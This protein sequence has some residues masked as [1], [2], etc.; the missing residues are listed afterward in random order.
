[1]IKPKA[2]RAFAVVLLAGVLIGAAADRVLTSTELRSLSP[3]E[4]N[5]QYQR[6]LLSILQPMNHYPTGMRR[7]MGDVWT[8]TRAVA[9]DYETLCQ[10]DMLLLYYEPDQRDGA[11][12]EWTVKPA[13]I[14]A[15]R[16]YRFVAPPKPAH[17]EAIERDG[18]FRSAFDPKCRKADKPEG[19]NEWYG[20]F[21]AASPE[22]AMDGGFALLAVQEWAK[23]PA[24]QFGECIED[25]DPARCK[26]RVESALDLNMIGAVTACTPDKPGTICLELGKYGDLFTIR[27]RQTGKPMTAQDVISVDPEVMIIV[28]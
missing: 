15:E 2:L 19:A 26:V 27:A 21:E 10:R 17:L 5:R 28:T 11:Y 16:A 7:L 24:S 20:W 8:H 13:G 18:Y 6:D 14:S 22:Q 12:E 25:A 4:A 23:R 3:R 1:M 9:T